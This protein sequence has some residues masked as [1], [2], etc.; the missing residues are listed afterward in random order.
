MRTSDGNVTINAKP[1]NIKKQTKSTIQP[2]WLNGQSSDPTNVDQLRSNNT[3]SAKTLNLHQ[4]QLKS[5]QSTTGNVKFG[6]IGSLN[7][8]DQSL[9]Q[10]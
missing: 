2:K 1:K 4:K 9:F 7:Q 5:Q 3:P 6:I 10:L 8:K